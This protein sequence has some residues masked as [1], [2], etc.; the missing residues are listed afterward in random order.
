ML[1][2]TLPH[3]S[4]AKR[5]QIPAALFS[6]SIQ[7]EKEYV[8]ISQTIYLAKNDGTYPLYTSNTTMSLRQTMLDHIK[9]VSWHSHAGGI[10]HQLCII[11]EI[12]STHH[13]TQYSLLAIVHGTWDLISRT[14]DQ[15]CNP[16]IGR[17]ESKLLDHQGR[18]ST[19]T[20]CGFVKLFLIHPLARGSETFG[21]TIRLPCRREKTIC[22]RFGDILQEGIRAIHLRAG[23]AHM[24][25]PSKKFWRELW[26]S[27]SRKLK[28]RWVSVQG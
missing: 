1:I 26:L 27:T 2:K 12:Y 4:V 11:P 17:T 5:Q 8:P 10:P 6:H 3:N 21:L 23:Q 24:L 22:L 9:T 20:E 16:C 18:L 25:L 7:K 19:L 13:E 28:K 14:R 15:T